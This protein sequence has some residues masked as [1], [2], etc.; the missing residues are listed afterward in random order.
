MKI[1][2]IKKFEDMFNLSFTNVVNI[3]NLGIYSNDDFI[4]HYINIETNYIYSFDTI[5][6]IWLEINL[7]QHEILQK[8]NN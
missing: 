6:E 7:Y 4:D 3:E 1:I 5:G 2:F 8:I